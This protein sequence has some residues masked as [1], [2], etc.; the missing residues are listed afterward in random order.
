MVEW[1]IICGRR[2]AYYRRNLLNGQFEVWELSFVFISFLVFSGLAILV[3]IPH[4]WYN[5][6]RERIPHVSKE[7]RVWNYKKAVAGSSLVA[8]F[9]WH[10]FWI[11]FLSKFAIYFVRLVTEKVQTLPQLIPSGLFCSAFSL[12]HGISWFLY[13]VFIRGANMTHQGVIFIQIWLTRGR[14]RPSW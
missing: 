1:S 4:I 6:C 8:T 12:S 5:I 13:Y 7:R 9:L 10:W 14:K 3:R 11:V 2:S